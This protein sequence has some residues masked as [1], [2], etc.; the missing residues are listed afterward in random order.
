MTDYSLQVEWPFEVVLKK[1][2]QEQPQEPTSEPNHYT[3][4]A[5]P[6]V[7]GQKGTEL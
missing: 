5:E 7:V 2:Y 4:D 6:G 3:M 1:E